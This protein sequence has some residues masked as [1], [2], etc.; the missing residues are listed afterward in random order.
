MRCSRASDYCGPVR[1]KEI[2]ERNCVDDDIQNAGRET[3]FL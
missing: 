1:E 3:D 2:D